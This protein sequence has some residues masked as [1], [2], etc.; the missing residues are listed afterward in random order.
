MIAGK[1]HIHAETAGWAKLSRCRGGRGEERLAQGTGESG[2]HPRGRGQLAWPERSVGKDCAG[3]G[4]R[5]LSEEQVR[6]S[7]QA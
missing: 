4:D 3:Q 6:P 1:N 5:T 2:A 7:A